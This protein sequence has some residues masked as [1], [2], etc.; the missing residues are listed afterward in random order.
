M[1]DRDGKD[2]LDRESL[3]ALRQECLSMGDPGLLRKLVDLFLDAAPGQIETMGQALAGSQASE[4]ARIAHAL[5]GSAATLGVAGVRDLCCE[6]ERGAD[7][8]DLA[9]AGEMLA[10]LE[11]ELERARAAL[12]AE[13]EANPA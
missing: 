11:T 10:G 5:R 6:L 12:M 4:L 9:Q 8:G 3:E 7:A 1:T 13:L 2:P